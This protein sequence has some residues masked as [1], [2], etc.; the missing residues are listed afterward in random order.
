MVLDAAVYAVSLFLTQGLFLV[1]GWDANLG[2]LTDARYFAKLGIPIAILW[3]SF[4]T[5]GLYDLKPYLIWEELH[6][7]VKGC[8]IAIILVFFLFYIV[9]VANLTTAVV[10]SMG[11]FIVLSGLS[12]LLY[13][14]T[15]FRL[16]LLVTNVIV[17]GGGIQG[18]KFCWNVEAHPFTTYK[19]LGFVVDDETPEVQE[20]PILGRLQDL[21]RIVEEHQVDEAVIAIP[22][23]TRESFLSVM[24]DLEVRVRSIRFIPDMYGVLTFSPEITEFNRVLTISANQGLLSPVRRLYKRL[25]DLLFG[26]LGALILLPL[27]VVVTILVKLDDGGKVLFTQQRVGLNGRPI[28]IYKF[29]T[30]VKD[31]E[32]VLADMMA[33]DPVIRE[34][35]QREKKLAND[36]RITKVGNFLRKTSLDEFPQFI[37]VLKG[38]MSVVGPRPYL[39]TEIRDMGDKYSSIVKIKPG[40]T[41]LWQ[42][43]GRN[44]LPFDERVVLDQYYVRNWTVWFDMVIIIRTAFSVL[45]R[46][47]V[48]G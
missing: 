42:A 29:R 24:N 16:N 22:K 40:I 37:N 14:V 47:G 15:L 23:A 8:A 26:L 45:A 36:P 11:V 44:E 10:V 48:K 5:R 12:R 17:V 21:G 19:V 30:M 35:Y 46:K 43:S 13:R 32:K 9:K 28:R 33:K 39:F 25:L 7:I 18:V 38:E 6:R 1:L 3:L 20:Y 34:E 41:G 27:Y 31:A 4:L 2:T